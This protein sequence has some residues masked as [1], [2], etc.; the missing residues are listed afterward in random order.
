[1]MTVTK[2][3]PPNKNSNTSDTNL[4]VLELEDT[5]FINNKF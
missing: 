2:L 5:N 1:M 4:I 3:W